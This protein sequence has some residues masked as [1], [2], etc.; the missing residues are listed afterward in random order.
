MPLDDVALDPLLELIVVLES[1]KGGI[2]LIFGI[3][4]STDSFF[5]CERFEGT[6]LSAV[7]ERGYS[8]F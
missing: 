1:K 3:T 2:K 4:F 8:C 6:L 5:S 7:Y